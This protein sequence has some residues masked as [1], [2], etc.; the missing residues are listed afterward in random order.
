M[1]ETT[2]GRVGSTPRGFGIYAEGVDLYGESFS[3]QE[4]S[5][6][7]EYAL[8]IGQDRTPDGTP[9]RAHLSVE[10]ARQV[11]DAITAWLSAVEQEK[12]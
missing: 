3:V 2:D 1:S 7:T 8:W 6:A 10:Q 9:C 12:L 5:L 4:S 11:R